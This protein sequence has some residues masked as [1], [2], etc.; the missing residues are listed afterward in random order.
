MYFYRMKFPCSNTTTKEKYCS[1]IPWAPLK[2][3]KFQF[4]KNTCFPVLVLL[5]ICSSAI[6]FPSC[7][8]DNLNVAGVLS[9]STDTLTFDTLFTTLGSTTRFFTVKNNQKHPVTISN[10]K[11]GGGTAT[12]YRMN[13]DGDAGTIFT[14]IEIPAKDSIYVFVEVTIDPNTANLPFIVLDSVQFTVEDK[15]QQVILQT[16][17]QN[18]HFFNGDS[19][20]TNAVWDN[21]LP[22][23]ILNYLQIKPG[24]SLT[25]NKGCNVYFG[26]GAAMLVEGALNVNGTDTSN[27]VTFRG[28]RLDK[29][30]ADRP[31]DDFPGQYAGVFFLRNSTGNFNYLKMRNSAYGINVGNIKTSD[32]AA[33]NILQLQSLNLNSAPEVSIKNSMIYNHAFFG[34]FGFMGKIRAENTLVYNCGKN[35]VGLYFGGDYEFTHCTFYTR[36]SAYVS[37][38]QE[39]AFYMN[40]FFSYDITQPSINAD[41]SR[42]AFV[43][44]I[45]YGTLDEEIVAEG[46]TQNIKKIDLSFSHCI[47]KTK[48]TLNPPVFV[49]CKKDDPQFVNIMRNNYKLKVTSPG[50]NFGIPVSVVTDLEGFSRSNPPDIGAYEIQ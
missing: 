27:M 1:D 44:C 43:N 35:V 38:T 9:F 10:I 29:D 30:V 25:I 6:F 31:Y 23:V 3:N 42:A 11:I 24:A 47:L 48:E 46:S 49:V 39:P 7:K 14:D 16:Y 37:H 34:I 17:G 18:A 21:D 8:K 2:L 13:V 22:Y 26:G 45:L 33:D 15:L 12:S 50:S 19:I 28:V 32:N 41:S 4:M 36:G 5:L 20:E 40:N